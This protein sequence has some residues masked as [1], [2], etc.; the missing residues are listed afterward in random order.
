MAKLADIAIT[1]YIFIVIAR[2]LISWFNV[3]PANP[4][5]QFLIKA[6]EPVLSRIRNIIPNFG[7]LD[8][9]PMILIFGL[10][11]AESFLVSTLRDL[12]YTFS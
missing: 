4:I 12:A 9:S 11:I 6:T 5:V 8:L 1:L 10:Y 2:A 3:D 7:G